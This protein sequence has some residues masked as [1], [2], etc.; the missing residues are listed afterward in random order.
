MTTLIEYT[1]SGAVNHEKKW[2]RGTIA[3]EIKKNWK[4][5]HMMQ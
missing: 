1:K 2:Q 4:K 3:T 5:T